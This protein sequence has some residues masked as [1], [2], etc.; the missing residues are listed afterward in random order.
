MKII[1]LTP[2]RAPDGKVPFWAV[3]QGALKYGLSYP[4]M[5]Q[6]QDIIQ[7]RLKKGLKNNFY[8]LRNIT[9]PRSSILVPF[10]LVGP[11]GVYVI[12]PTH[13]TG[14]YQAKGAEWG[15]LTKNQFKAESIN[16]L[17]QTHNLTRAV[18]VYFKRQNMTLE[19]V[20]GILMAADPGLHVESSRP[21]VRVLMADAIGGFVRSLRQERPQLTDAEVRLLVRRLQDPD[22]PAEEERIEPE[23]FFVTDAERQAAEEAASEPPVPP[24]LPARQQK[25]PSRRAAARTPDPSLPL[26]LNQKQWLLLIGMFVVEILLIFALLIIVA[27]N[28]V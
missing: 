5:L 11:P 23:D 27:M 25:K 1:D 2:G 7:A 9:L 13:L 22:S 8:L 6:A 20:E 17:K 18:Q 26:G 10:I 4:K 12:V 16:L 19:R 21:I 28:S 15:T 14:L 3:I 24:E